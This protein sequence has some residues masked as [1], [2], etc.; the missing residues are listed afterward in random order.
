LSNQNQ[1]PRLTTEEIEIRIWA[2]VVLSVIIIFAGITT[3]MLYSVIYI[4]QPIKAMAPI[5]Q[6]FVKMLNDIVLL[7]V[8]GI[9]GIMGNKGVR[10][11]SNAINTLSTPPSGATQQTPAM[12]GTSAIPGAAFGAMPVFV[13]PEFDESWRP[14]PPPTKPEDHL[15]PEREE[16]ANEREAA[17]AEL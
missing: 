6:A 15:H 11:A 14:G 2:I 12:A 17:K 10:A 4:A 13:N 1:R 8:G 9:G 16:I 7:I 5:D 3:A